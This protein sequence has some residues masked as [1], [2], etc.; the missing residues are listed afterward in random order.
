MGSIG[1]N[2]SRQSVPARH[3]LPTRVHPSAQHPAAHLEAAL[4]VARHALRQLSHRA[5]HHAAPGVAG[6]IS[7]QR[8]RLAAALQ[9]GEAGRRRRRQVTMEQSP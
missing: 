9:G 4:G 8:V 7:Q 2:Q 1:L 6:H 5:R 3:H